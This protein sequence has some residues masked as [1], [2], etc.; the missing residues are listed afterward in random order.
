[1]FGKGFWDHVILGVSFWA[2]DEHSVYL[3][4][5]SKPPKTE[6]WWSDEYN[7]QLKARF[8]VEKNLEAV[9]IDSWS[10]QPGF[11]DDELQQ[12][13][14]QRETKKLWDRISAMDAFEFKSIQDVIEELDECNKLLD[15]SIEQLQNDMESRVVEISL[16]NDTISNN[17]DYIRENGIEIAKV[18]HNVVLNEE[19]ISQN[20]KAITDNKVEIENTINSVNMTLEASISNVESNIEDVKTD[21]E[22]SILSVEALVDSV[23]TV[24]EASI[25]LVKQEIQK[26]VAE[27][28]SSIDVNS[29]SISHAS[30]RIYVST[31][32]IIQIALLRY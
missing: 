29:N 18:R 14:F 20:L 23:K 25:D 30:N 1:M 24:M 15:G 3:R 5:I 28:A 31:L 21:L 10:Q 32:C 8:H 12:V 7:R 4:N 13:A 9:F 22:A 27:L 16:L 19:H 26:N 2:Y 6:S 17:K 11:L